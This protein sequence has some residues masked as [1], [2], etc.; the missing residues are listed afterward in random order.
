MSNK[1]FV[2][3][4]PVRLQKEEIVEHFSKYGKIVQCKMKKNSKTGRSLGY[5]HISFEDPAVYFQLV[6]TAVEFHGRVCECKPLLKKQEL[7]THLSEQQRL[8]L[9]VSNL[10]PLASNEDL[11]SAFSFFAPVAFAYVVRESPSS[12]LNKGLGCVVFA[13]EQELTAFLQSD[14]KVSVLGKRVKLAPM[15]SEKVP[16]SSSTFDQNKSDFML[17]AGSD[18]RCQKQRQIAGKDRASESNPRCLDASPPLATTLG[19][20]YQSGGDS[21]QLCVAG[22]SRHKDCS[23]GSDNDPDFDLCSAQGIRVI[24]GPAGSQRPEK[25]RTRRTGFSLFEKSII[26]DHRD[27]SSLKNPEGDYSGQAKPLSRRTHIS[28]GELQE[29]PFVS[30]EDI[31]SSEPEAQALHL[32]QIPEGFTMADSC[33][34]TPDCIGSTRLTRNSASMTFTDSSEHKLRIRRMEAVCKIS[35]KIDERL[36][37]YKLNLDPSHGKA[38]Q[39]ASPHWARPSRGFAPG[40]NRPAGTSASVFSKAPKK[41]SLS[42][43]DD[44]SDN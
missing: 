13:S 3:G 23:T 24:K 21:D 16:L 26:E 40:F 17:L 19:L 30:R 32:T 9:L 29:L 38:I 12:A 18:R 35:L 2:S 22:Q 25:V 33:K 41:M 36:D 43:R 5:V 4:I 31:N 8:R 11:Y 20:A 44:K 6:H 10:S 7:Q 34:A 37:N 28:I 42:T 1:L 15:G 27:Q 39:A 14:I